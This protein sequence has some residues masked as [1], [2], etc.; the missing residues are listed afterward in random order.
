MKVNINA[1]LLGSCFVLPVKF[2][3]PPRKSVW[4][5]LPSL[6]GRDVFSPISLF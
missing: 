5:F 3:P 4:K 6:E 1:D 2:L